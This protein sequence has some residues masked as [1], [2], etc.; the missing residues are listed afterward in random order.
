[1][2][3]G[4]C[5]VTS[6]HGMDFLSVAADATP[7]VAIERAVD[8]VLRFNKAFVQF[9]VVGAGKVSGQHL[10]IEWDDFLER[11]RFKFLHVVAFQA[12]VCEDQDIVEESLELSAGWIPTCPTFFPFVI[13]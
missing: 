9:Y 3:V 7:D 8:S 5:L 10:L 12:R 11:P 4:D 13:S 1:M 6:V 2:F